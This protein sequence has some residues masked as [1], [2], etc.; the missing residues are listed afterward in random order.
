MYIVH[1]LKI[2][3]DFLEVLSQ[4]HSPNHVHHS[5]SNLG[6]PFGLIQVRFAE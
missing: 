6:K 3:Q 5:V 1:L 2:F 4:L